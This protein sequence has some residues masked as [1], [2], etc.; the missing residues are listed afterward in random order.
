MMPL[1]RNGAG[2]AL[3]FLICSTLLT[4]C[5]SAAK[6]GQ[7]A[8]R[9]PHPSSLLPLE[10]AAQMAGDPHHAARPTAATIRTVGHEEF[11]AD[12]EVPAADGADL[13]ARQVELSLPQLV[14]E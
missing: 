3:A 9:E 10:P 4:G 12:E 11:F 5:S 1:V 7:I 13:F 6:H 8:V 2:C 14:D